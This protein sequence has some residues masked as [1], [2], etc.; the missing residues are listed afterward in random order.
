MSS[1]DKYKYFYTILAFMAIL[2]AFLVTVDLLIISQQKDMIY[3]GFKNHASQ[4]A[5]LVRIALREPMIRKKYSRIEEFLKTWSK[6]HDH[7]V[8]ITAMTPNNSILFS[9]M[10]P[11]PVEHQLTTRRVIQHSGK[12][13]LTIYTT[14]DLDSEDK[15]LEALTQEL[16]LVSILFTL[17]LG[18][19]LWSTIKKLV[20]TPLNKEILKREKAQNDLTNTLKELNDIKFALD[21][22]A[23]VTITDAKGAITY[24]NDKFCKIA[25]YSKDELIGQNHRIVSSGHHSKEFFT[26]MWS[27]IQGAK[28]WKGVIKNKAKDGSYYW[29]D[30]TIFPFVDSEGKPYQY[31]VICTDVTERK[32]DEEKLKEYTVELEQF[33]QLA[34]DRELTM[35]DL[36]K[37][38]NKLLEELNREPEYNIVDG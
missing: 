34:V 30:L 1:I 2:I 37:Q 14:L 27:T 8:E 29:V 12:V 38:V 10:R 36:K 19:A 22:H 33:N 11:N 5:D 7:L 16:V 3:D 32:E 21:E 9:Y 6:K 26:N 17:L 25:K 23:I 4:E 13:L 28:V 35:I 20:I 18:P 15:R 24:V 31:V